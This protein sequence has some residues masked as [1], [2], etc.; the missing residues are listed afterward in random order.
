[1]HSPKKIV[2]ER[3][4]EKDVYRFRRLLS[5]GKA[6]LRALGSAPVAFREMRGGRQKQEQ[7]GNKFL[8]KFSK[9]ELDKS[10]EE[11]KL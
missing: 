7:A 6:R 2:L 10:E 9:K 1:M 5:K 8:Q 3:A 11:V 4:F